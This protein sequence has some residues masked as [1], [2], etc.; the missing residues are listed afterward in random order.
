MH[1]LEWQ[2][3]CGSNSKSG[4]TELLLDRFDGERKRKGLHHAVSTTVTSRGGD[5]AH[6][7]GS[8]TERCCKRRSE[9][10][11]VMA[12]LEGSGFEG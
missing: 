1:K 7:S 9:G 3:V 10:M 4:L 6:E 2:L 8:T 5:E 11:G 12:G